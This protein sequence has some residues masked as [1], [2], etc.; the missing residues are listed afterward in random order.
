MLSLAIIIEAI[1]GVRAAEIPLLGGVVRPTDVLIPEAVID[2]RRAIP[3]ALFIAL[4]G[5]KTD[6]HDYVQAA[7]DAGAALAIVHRPV[8]GHPEL[9]LRHG[10]PSAGLQGLPPDGPF[11][12]RVGDSLEAMQQI[13]R[14]WRSKLNLEVIGITGSV[15]KSTTKETVADVLEQRFHTLRNEGNLNNEIG[16]PLTILRATEQHRRAVLEMGFY[17]PGEIS[18]LCEI[19]RPRI[20]I[21]TNVG[22][23]HA[24]RA[25]TQEAIARGKSELVQALPEDG[26]AILNYD[27]AWV[28]GMAQH[29]QAR[30]FFYGRDARAD[31]WVDRIE[32][33][34]LRGMRFRLH[35]RDEVIPMHIPALGYPAVDSALRAAAAGLMA[36]LSWDQIKRGLVSGRTQLRMNASHNGRGALILDDTYNAAPES[37]VAALNLLADLHGRKV[38][39]LGDMLELGPY[40]EEGHIQV[41]KRSA[42]VAEELIT[43]GKRARTIARIARQ[44]G[45][46]HQHIA[47]YADSQ[48][49]AEGLANR[50]QD[51]D[52]VLIKGSHGVHM[53]TIV[54]ALEG[55][56]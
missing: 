56:G 45:M 5:E 27:D 6:G 24:E 31:L 29:T 52:V 3:G 38:A 14:I 22:T 54:A 41:G 40:E 51:G 25:G 21:V 20:G 9:D 36:G 42:E 33:L 13:A 2:S 19:A 17:V 50:F 37:T 8:A 48:Q 15:G 44:E 10:L 55:E 32:G 43:V 26:T 30:V 4:P 12:V 1:T 47:E 16:L 11:C 34:G 7:F 23:V 49:A 18:F 35:Y 53:E 39:V 46:P 28:R